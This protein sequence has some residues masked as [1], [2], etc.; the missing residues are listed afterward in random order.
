MGM[1]LNKCLNNM[2]FPDETYWDGGKMVVKEKKGEGD[3][4]T[5]NCKMSS[6]TK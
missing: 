2:E 1:M 5:P 6:M 4:Q 3:R